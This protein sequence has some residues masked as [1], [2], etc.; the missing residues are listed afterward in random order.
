ML[1]GLAGTVPFSLSTAVNQ[2]MSPAGMAVALKFELIEEETPPAC[3]PAMDACK[4]RKLV[5]IFETGMRWLLL[6]AA[7][8]KFLAA[9]LTS[10]R[11]LRSTCQVVP[12]VPRY[13]A[14][15]GELSDH[16]EVAKKQ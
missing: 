14:W 16:A 3:T 10:T 7:A 5:S 2:I 12:R 6:P 13:R 9:A 8:V 4:S 1:A 15:P 11:G